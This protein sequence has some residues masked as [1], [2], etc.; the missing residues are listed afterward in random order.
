[1]LKGLAGGGTKDQGSY[2]RNCENHGEIQC[3][4]SCLNVAFLRNSCRNSCHAELTSSNPADGSALAQT[5]ETV[6]LTFSEDLLV[7][8]VEIAVTNS[9]Q[10]LVDNVVVSTERNT[11]TTIW[12]EDLPGGEYRVAYRVVSNDG[13]PITGVIDFN[14]PETVVVEESAVPESTQEEVVSETETVVAEP[15]SE[16][17]ISEVAAQDDTSQGISPIWLIIIGLGIGAVIGFV[18]LKRG[19]SRASKN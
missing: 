18:M 17:P 5:P 10:E 4:G 6:E 13:H 16:Q 2:P 19:A 9:D 1:M 11:V 15:I 3:L 7:D 12:P 14:Y 8:T